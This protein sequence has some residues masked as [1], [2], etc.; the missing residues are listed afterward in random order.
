MRIFLV[1]Q[2]GRFYISTYIQLMDDKTLE[3]IQAAYG[4]DE[5]KVSPVQS[6]LINTTLKVGVGAHTYLLQQVNTNVFHNPGWIDENL[7]MLATYLKHNT[8]GYLFTAPVKMI[9][10]RSLLEIGNSFYRVFDWVQGSHT[11]DVVSKPEQAFEAAR[12]FG[13][14]TALLKDFDAEKLHQSLPDFHNL[15]LRYL[16]F[17]QA[18]QNGNTERIQG[19]TEAIGYLQSQTGIVKRYETFIRH[20][21]AK[22]RVTHHDTK[23]SNVLFDEEDKGICVIDLDTVMPGYFLS[24]VGDMFRT[25]ICPVSEEE[26]ELG[27]VVVRKDFMKAIENGYLAAMAGELS[28]FEKDHFYFGGEVLIYMQAIRFLTDHLNNDVYYGSRYAGQNLVR[29][30]N[31]VRLLEEFQYSL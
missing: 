2:Y 12:Q 10:G 3:I 28:Q 7:V 4:W 14:F 13:Q 29:A 24:D 17:K 26:K 22:K 21:D 11:I 9:N 8:P 18:V 1:A 19:S 23:I 15:S 31:Q 25:Y 5:M 30:E 20:P 27:R 16:Q 6:G